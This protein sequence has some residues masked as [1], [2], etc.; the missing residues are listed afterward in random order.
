MAFCNGIEDEVLIMKH[1]TRAKKRYITYHRPCY[2][3]ELTQYY[4]WPPSS[5]YIEMTNNALYV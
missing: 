3:N 2:L 1:R 5:V 4:P